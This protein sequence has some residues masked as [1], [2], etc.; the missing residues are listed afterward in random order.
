MHN[1]SNNLK[2]F[3]TQKKMTQKQIA[4]HLNITH[5]AYNY[6]EKGTREPNLNTLIKLAELFGVSLDILTGRYVNVFESSAVCPK[7]KAV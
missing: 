3:R 6:Y 7:M 1:L 5:T 2:F 4:D